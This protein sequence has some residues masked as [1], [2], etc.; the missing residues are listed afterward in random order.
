MNRR[1]GGSRSPQTAE[2]AVEVLVVAGVLSGQPVRPGPMGKPNAA[3]PP[4]FFIDSK[5]TTTL[6]QPRRPPWA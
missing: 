1:A 5:S 4:I 6:Q 2:A 3:S